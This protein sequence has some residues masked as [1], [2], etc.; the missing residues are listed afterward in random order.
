MQVSEDIINWK[1]KNSIDF[2]KSY[3]VNVTKQRELHLKNANESI[4]KACDK[5]RVLEIF[6]N[7][8]ATKQVILDWMSNNRNNQDEI[9][10]DLD[11]SMFKQ[12][13]SF[14]I[15]KWVIETSMRSMLSTNASN[16]KGSNPIFSQP[17]SRPMSYHQKRKSI[18]T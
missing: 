14:F 3:N 17:N 15:D 16:M 4:F 11:T 13:G 1:T 5:W 18:K 12:Q 10:Y 9:T 2:S 7:C 6:A 8:P